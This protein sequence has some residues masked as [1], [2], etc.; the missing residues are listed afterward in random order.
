MAKKV[1]IELTPE[2]LKSSRKGLGLYHTPPV[3]ALSR[4]VIYRQIEIA[5]REYV[6]SHKY[7]HVTPE[8]CDESWARFYKHL[9]NRLGPVK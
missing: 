9:I 3:G 7:K 2:V 8:L 6:M 4:E 5:F 1:E